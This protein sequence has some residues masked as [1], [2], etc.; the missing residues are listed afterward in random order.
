MVGF[1]QKRNHPDIFKKNPNLG[2]VMEQRSRLL[3]HLAFG[4]WDHQRLCSNESE[5]N[6]GGPQLSENLLS[7]WKENTL[8]ETSQRP[9]PVSL[10]HHTAKQF[11]MCLYW[12]YSTVNHRRKIIMV[13][14]FREWIMSPTISWA[15]RQA[16]L[17]VCEPTPKFQR[18]GLQWHT[19]IQTMVVG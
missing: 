4:S 7:Q 10:L 6:T 1:L 16:R 8:A 12:K 13:M 17:L 15:W 11:Y 2:I 19:D 5:I 9:L 14:S 3:A 18:L